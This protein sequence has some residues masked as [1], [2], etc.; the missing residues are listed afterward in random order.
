LSESSPG[1]QSWVAGNAIGVV[2]Q[3]TA[4]AKRIKN[5]ATRYLF[6]VDSVVCGNRYILVWTPNLRH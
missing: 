2:P 5:T 3:G 4:E 6:T 1:R